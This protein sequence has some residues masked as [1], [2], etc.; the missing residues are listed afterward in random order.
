MDIQ[1]IPFDTLL[2]EAE[3]FHG[4]L[5]G[6]I[7]TGVRMSLR[8]LQ[9]IG[10]GDPKGEDRKRLMVFVEIDRCATDAITSVTG[11]R[12]GKR[13]MKIKDF[14]KMAATF[15]NLETG[16]AVRIC[17]RNRKDSAAPAAPEV[18]KATIQAQSDEELFVIRP[19]KVPLTDGDLPGS[20]VRKAICARCGESVLDMRDVVLGDETLCRPCSEG[21]NYYLLEAGV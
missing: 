15:I 1:T 4:H 21:A 18:V 12:P 13:T 10:I 19:V 2:A 6:G 16:R 17:A 14:G 5:C 20:P 8:G 3:T 9:E 11:C 7:V